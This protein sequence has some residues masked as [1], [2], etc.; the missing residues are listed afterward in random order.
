MP[1]NIRKTLPTHTTLTKAD[2]I[3]SL[4]Q[5]GM[6][7]R[8]KAFQVIETLL[9]LMKSTLESG[10]DL[11]ISGFGKFVVK[12]TKPRKGRDLSTGNAIPLD[13]RR[14]VVFKYSPNLRKKINS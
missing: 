4:F 1:R 6:F 13:A 7:P 9:E 12:D 5:Y 10:E 8:P 11:L 3:E 2:L 14:V